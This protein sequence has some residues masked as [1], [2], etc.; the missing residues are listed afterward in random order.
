[1]GESKGKIFR[2]DNTPECSALKATE[3][4]YRKKA[5]PG[6]L[7]RMSSKGDPLMACGPDCATAID[8]AEAPRWETI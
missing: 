6:W 2:C 5:P 4:S 1:M 3:T 7:L 8:E